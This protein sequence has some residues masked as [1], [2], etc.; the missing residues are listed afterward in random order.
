MKHRW[1]KDGNVISPHKTEREC[2]NG[3]GVVKVTRHEADGPRDV[4]WVEFWRDLDRIEG[5][6]TPPCISGQARAVAY[7]ARNYPL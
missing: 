2:Q 7:N 3:C 4:H 5:E 6:G 1:P